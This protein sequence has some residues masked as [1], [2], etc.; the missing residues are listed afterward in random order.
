MITN[1]PGQ[2]GVE[3]PSQMNVKPI[4][5]ERYAKSSAKASP[6]RF[7]RLKSYLRPKSKKSGK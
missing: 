3:Q 4:L 1:Q 6:K 2:M 5:K 7:S